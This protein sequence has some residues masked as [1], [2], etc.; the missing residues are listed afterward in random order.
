MKFWTIQSQ[1]VLEIIEKEDVY[2][3]KFAMSQYNKKYNELYNFM[4]KSFNNINNLNCEGLI[5]SFSI[6]YED[7]IY[8]I[9]NI[10]AFRDFINMNKDKVIYLWDTFI[11]N[12]CKILELEMDLTFNDLALSFNKFQYI[13]P[14]PVNKLLFD[15]VE[16]Q[17]NCD[18][19]LSN[20][21]KGIIMCSGEN[22]DLIQSHLPYIK[23]LDIKNVYELFSLD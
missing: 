22:Y 7:M 18:L 17:T 12:N 9:P 19:V 23:K 15:P 11:K 4:L 20:I 2:H 14:D 1:E 8:P 16:Y 5:F 6:S 21:E 13:M 10:E 3:P